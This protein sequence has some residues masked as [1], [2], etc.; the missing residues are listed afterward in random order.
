M[1]IQ[2]LQY[3]E[4]IVKTGSINEAAKQLFLTQPSVSNAIKELENEL[5]L[6]LL[7]RS[8][9]GVSL[10]DEGREFMIYA[11][12]ILDQVNLLEE[13][14]KQ[15]SKRKQAFSVSAQHYAFV[16]HAFVELIRGV[17]SEKYQFTLRETETQN[18]LTDLS[19]FKSEIGILY[20]NDFNQKVLK[21]LFKE[22][23]LIFTPLFDAKPHVFVGIQ[24]P[25]T[26]KT[27]VSLE[28]LLDY[29]Y[30]SYE[31]GEGNSFYFSEEILSTLDHKKQIK[32]S[33][34]ATIFNLMVGLNGYTISSGII[35][36]E[37]ND[38]KIVA[39]P[40][41]VEDTITLGWLKHEQTALTPIANE[42]LEMLKTHIRGFGFTIIGE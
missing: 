25:L 28:D 37:L 11:R 33:D 6:K 22:E 8:K 4:E 17:E 41:E 9:M 27:T 39:I 1:R 36:S 34:R 38:D 12:Q 24:N 14:Y 32:V 18:I 35:S 2:Q 15:Q 5:N 10:T 21:K 13:R 3:L 20:L 16:V 42:Y 40:L 31:Q 7:L 29:P 19:S 23:N 26:K 30:L